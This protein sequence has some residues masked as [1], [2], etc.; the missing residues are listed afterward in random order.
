[1]AE[2]NDQNILDMTCVDD[3]DD[4]IEDVDG[5]PID[6]LDEYLMQL[7]EEPLE[8]YTA[9]NEKTAEARKRMWYTFCE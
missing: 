1:M 5:L 9:V 4:L 2:P 8:D 7:E 3:L 6:D